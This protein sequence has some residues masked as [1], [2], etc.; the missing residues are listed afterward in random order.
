MKSYSSTIPAKDAV[1]PDSVKRFGRVTLVTTYNL[2][3]T[4]ALVLNLPC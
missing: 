3:G 4:L 1:E 2:S